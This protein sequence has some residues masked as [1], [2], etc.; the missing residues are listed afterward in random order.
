MISRKLAL[1]DKLLYFILILMGFQAFPVLRIG[2]SFKVYELIS[3]VLIFVNIA[4]TTSNKRTNVISIITFLFFVF[5]PIA[6]FL[7]SRLFLDYPSAFFTR[8]RE[9]SGLRYNYYVFPLLQIMYMVF[10]YVVFTSFISARNIYVNLDQILKTA[11]LLGTI[12]ACYS[13]FAMYGYDFIAKFPEFIQA[14]GPYNDRSTGLSQEPGAYVLYQGWICLFI[15]FSKNLYSKSGWLILLI[16]NVTSLILTFSTILV[17]LGAII[18]VSIFLFRLTAKTKRKFLL[19]ITILLAAVFSWVFFFDDQGLVDRYFINK[20][21]DFAASKNDNTLTSGATRSYTS[22][23]GY[24]IFKQ[25]PLFGVGVGS[26][27]YYMYTYEYKMGIL[28]FGERL[29][30]NTFPQNLFSCV[31]SEQGIVGAIFLFVLLIYLL[32]KF[33]IKRNKSGYHKMFLI[34]ML[35]TLF[36]M[37][38]ISP[39]YLLF[40]WVYAAFGIGYIKFYDETHSTGN[41]LVISSGT[42]LELSKL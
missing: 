30:P 42:A 17:A 4:Q 25:Y 38:S 24:E 27:N 32:Y 23:I 12:I 39:A 28:F 5:S 10:N 18:L 41:N 22:G 11:I 1:R 21:S 35:F 3:L 19:A 9:T 8:Y 36:S 6:S 26:S 33:W 20:I 14:K 15:F 29:Q 2:G 31:F 16:I 34:G 40:L 13:L 37:F 7:Y